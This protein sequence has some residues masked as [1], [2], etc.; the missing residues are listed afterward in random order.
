MDAVLKDPDFMSETS[1]RTVSGNGAGDWDY[2]LAHA[3]YTAENE[4][5]DGGEKFSVEKKALSGAIHTLTQIK[6]PVINNCRAPRL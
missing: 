6:L 4:R 2:Q 5:C 3:A 1:P